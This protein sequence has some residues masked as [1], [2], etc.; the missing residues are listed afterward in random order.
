MPAILAPLYR[1][2]AHAGRLA[3][4]ALLL[5]ASRPMHCYPHLFDH[6]VKPGRPGA[7]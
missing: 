1:P 4:S 6:E 7:R 2:A 5:I 3:L